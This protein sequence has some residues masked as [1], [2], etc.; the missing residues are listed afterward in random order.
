MQ[1]KTGSIHFLADSDMCFQFIISLFSVLI[2]GILICTNVSLISFN[3][4]VTRISLID[5][6]FLLLTLHEFI[7]RDGMWCLLDFVA[8]CPLSELLDDFMLLNLLSSNSLIP[9]PK[10]RT[11][12]SGDRRG[13]MSNW[14]LNLLP[15]P[16]LT[17]CYIIYLF[18][19]SI[20]PN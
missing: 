17:S 4:A 13:R 7:G 18:S 20:D 12:F 9:H 16:W 14:S 15:V 3:T 6:S 5:W 11:L 1:G 2:I 8:L 10:Q 19:H